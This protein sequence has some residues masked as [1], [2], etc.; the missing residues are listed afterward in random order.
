M[1]DKVFFNVIQVMVVMAFAPI[2]KGILTRLKENL[3]SK[4][5]SSI[6]QP[7]RD[8]RKL[9]HKDEAV[10][11]DS[12]VGIPFHALHRLRYADLRS[13]ADPGAYGLSALFRL[14]GGYARGW[15]HPGPGRFLRH[16]GRHRHWKS[17]R[18][19][20]RQ[21]DPDGRFSRRDG[22]YDCFLYSFLPVSRA[23]QW[24]ASLLGR[25]HSG[26]VNVYA[27]Y[28]L[29]SLFIVLMIQGLMR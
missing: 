22:L 29:I 23:I 18:P 4:R 14:H 27:V 20:G 21:P 6:F 13:A 26:S 3:K 8:I 25:M 10:S 7:Y 16:A 2:V 12:S 9:F 28:V 1:I 15:V 19:D 5:G 11:M 17:I 24:T